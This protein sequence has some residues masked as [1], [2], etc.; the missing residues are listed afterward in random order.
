MGQK[1]YLGLRFFRKKVKKIVIV[2]LCELSD[3]DHENAIKILKL[4]SSPYKTPL[5]PDLEH[6]QNFQNFRNF[7]FFLISDFNDF[8]F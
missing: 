7:H 2:F 5:G 6:F 3:S 8:Q 4:F 1:G